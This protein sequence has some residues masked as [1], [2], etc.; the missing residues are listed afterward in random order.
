MSPEQSSSPRVVGTIMA[1]ARTNTA[2][3][4][5]QRATAIARAFT[6][7]QARTLA[8]GVLRRGAAS[9]RTSGSSPTATRPCPRV[10]T[11]SSSAIPSVASRISSSLNLP[12]QNACPIQ[13]LKSSVSS[14]SG[15]AAFFVI[16]FIFLEET[17][18]DDYGISRNPSGRPSKQSFSA[19][20]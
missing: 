10:T 13:N 17:L 15:L 11:T 16:D 19:V 2:F 3:P 6:T 14:N 18:G 20:P 7:T 8:S 5:C 9:L 4:C 1:T 12:I